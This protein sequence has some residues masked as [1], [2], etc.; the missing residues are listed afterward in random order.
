M[1]SPF[2]LS[3]PVSS[4]IQCLVCN[5]DMVGRTAKKG[6]NEGNQFYGCFWSPACRGAKEAL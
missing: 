6:P 4:V 5:S 1:T 3:S 2:S